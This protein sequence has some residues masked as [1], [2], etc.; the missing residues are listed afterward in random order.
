[1]SLSFIF[2]ILATALFFS[3]RSGKKKSETCRSLYT[4]L[5]STSAYHGAY[6]CILVSIPSLILI[7][8][9]LMLNSQLVE[10]VVIQNAAPDLRKD[11]EAYP[12]F[13]INQIKLVAEGIILS[14][15]PIYQKAAA[16]YQHYQ[17]LS[18]WSLSIIVMTLIAMGFTIGHSK[19]S[20]KFKARAKVETF[21][22][23][24]L[25]ICSLIAT[26]TTIGI[27][28]SLFTEAI[29]FF[30]DI[31]IFKF[32]FG[33][34]WSPQSAIDSQGNVIAS[35]FGAFPVFLGTLLIS[36][37]AMI[38]AG[39]IGLFA[40]IYLSEYAPL[41]IRTWT[42]PVIEILA[43]IPTVVYGFFAVITV[44]PF[45]HS[46]GLYFG[47]NISLESALCAGIVMGIMIIPFI[48]SIADDAINAVPQRLRDGSFG[49]GAT[50]SETIIKI[51]L[52]AA[53]PGIS[54]GFLLAISR[55]IGE[56]MIV[57]MAAGM[58]ANLTFNPFE[59][60]TTVTVQITSL[61]IGDQEFDNAKTLSAYGLA[62][63]L[64]ICTLILN[65]FAQITVKKYQE[66]YD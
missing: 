7:A 61:M 37:I 60:V 21:I 13:T 17:N 23:A 6:L 14:T 35:S 62:L 65:V 44:A 15:N 39:P 25:F 27:V 30:S 31:S 58:I 57:V 1:M 45:I 2:L 10:Y 48:S 52:P 56:T 46:I 24:C 63:I 38:V 53:L 26:L 20:L 41:I 9:W 11:F 49:L 22:K 55:A 33:T 16:T 4:P 36:M 47:L 66:K 64:F 28:L 18:R 29:K 5:S 32:L 40:A 59:S 12:L 50:H 43:G 19:I 54:S 51:I 34:H 3:Y 42:K 8:C